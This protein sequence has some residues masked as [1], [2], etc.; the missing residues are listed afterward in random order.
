MLGRKTEGS[1][2]CPSCGLLVGVNDDECLNCGRKRPGMWGF[3]PMIVQLARGGIAFDQIVIV[4]CGVLFALSLVIDPNGITMGGFDFLG[5]SRTALR[6]L[7]ASGVIPVLVEGRWWTLLSASWLHGGMLHIFFNMMWI[8]QLAPG[9]GDLYGVSRMIIIYMVAGLVG[10]SFS[11]FAVYIPI[12]SS[13]GPFRP[14]GITIGAS[15]SVFGLL[16]AMIYYGRRSGSSM[17]GRQARGMALLLF[18]FGLI[19]PGVDNWAHLG[20]FLGGYGVSKWLDPLS[21][22]RLDHL[23]VALIF[24]GLTALSVLLSLIYPIRPFG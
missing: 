13:F 22:E 1:V 6:K 7:G 2:V 18:I 14:G 16:G 15:A 21:Q 5:P 10:F 9:V 12:L 17:I 20:G 19:F 11:S 23:V 8:R 3:A 4:S 24:M